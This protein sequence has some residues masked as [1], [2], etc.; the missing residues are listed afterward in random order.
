M[1]ANWALAGSGPL[2]KVIQSA[3]SCAVSRRPL[4]PMADSVKRTG[5][6]VLMQPASGLR[7]LMRAGLPSNV[8]ST[9]S[10]ASKP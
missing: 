10:P 3:L 2:V 6:S 4:G 5:S 8:V 9:F 7:N 1:S